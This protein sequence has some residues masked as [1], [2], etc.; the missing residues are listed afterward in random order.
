M[1]GRAIITPLLP[2]TTTFSFQ[3]KHQRLYN[4]IVSA[5]CVIIGVSLIDFLHKHRQ[6]CITIPDVRPV[7]ETERAADGVLFPH[8][9]Q[10]LTLA[11]LHTLPQL[12]MYKAN[13][14]G[15]L[16]AAHQVTL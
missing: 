8:L 7:S 3:F 4:N 14:I 6:W 1:K 15:V 16:T 9:R 12:F 10:R 13:N 2:A 5:S 11:Y